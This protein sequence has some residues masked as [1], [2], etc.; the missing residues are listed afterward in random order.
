[1]RVEL[2]VGFWA[3][4]FLLLVLLLW[5]FSGVL[6]PF[7]AAV[8]LGYLLDPVVERLERFGMNRLGATLVIMASFALLL[9]LLS[10]LLVPVL[11]RQ[12]SSFVEA[13]PGYAVQLQGLISGEIERL[14]R[15]YSGGLIE[16]LGL[17]KDAGA[18]F[19]SATN[20]LVAQAAHWA[21]SFLNSVLTRGAALINLISLLVV[22]PVVTFY[23]L[24][25]WDR[26]VATID[27]L[28]PMRHRETVRELARE[29]HTAMAGFLRGQSLVCLFLG[30]WYG[31]GLSLI[32][33]NFGLLIGIMAGI[34]SFIPYVGSLTALI[35]ASTVAIVQ[36]WPRWHL[37]ILSLSVVLV[38]QFLEGNILSPK[39]VGGSVGLHPVWLIFALLAFGSLF[40]FTGLIAAVPLAAA[41]GVIL[42]FAIARYRESELYTGNTSTD[43]RLLVKTGTN[44]PRKEDR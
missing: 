34:L 19:A 41:A 21:G 5:L 25:D 36:D 6:L 22:T 40:G 7:V 42:R 43:A 17:G 33:L 9:T 1:M 30:A 24:L 4:A 20:D 38:G 8:V 16:K 2:Q 3:G 32:G 28:V 29:I 13:L 26:M 31:V 35:L 14:S 11:W 39:L 12:L 18:E 27:G 15:E 44:F 37:L 10:I 23:M